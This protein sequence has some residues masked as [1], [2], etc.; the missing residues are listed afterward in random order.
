MGSPWVAPISLIR[1]FIQVSSHAAVALFM[2]SI[3]LLH[4]I[5]IQLTALL[6][7]PRDPICSHK[8]TVPCSRLPVVKWSSPV[9]IS[10]GCHIQIPFAWI[11]RSVL[12]ESLQGSFSGEF[13]VELALVLILRR[14]RP[15]LICLLP[16]IWE[17]YKV[18]LDV[19]R[20]SDDFYPS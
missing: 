8:D 18:L 19:S 15:S 16:R 5:W 17:N 20:A 4:L 12:L 11:Q 1:S 13:F 6:A 7:F 9:C 2:L 14:P 10:V 3:L